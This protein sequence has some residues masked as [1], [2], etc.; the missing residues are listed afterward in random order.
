MSFKPKDF[1]P[2]KTDVSKTFKKLEALQKQRAAEELE[3]RQNVLNTLHE[4]REALV[5]LVK[6]ERKRE[7]GKRP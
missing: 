1:M 4:I 5:Y 7:Q 2:S 3:Y 6:R